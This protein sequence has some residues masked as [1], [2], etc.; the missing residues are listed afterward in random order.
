[1]QKE[2]K[3]DRKNS[4]PGPRELWG[5]LGLHKKGYSFCGEL[6]EKKEQNECFSG[7]RLNPGRTSFRRRAKT[8]GKKG[9]VSLER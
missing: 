1:L 6:D 4:C 5:G 7:K 2:F 8:I 3:K 9:Y